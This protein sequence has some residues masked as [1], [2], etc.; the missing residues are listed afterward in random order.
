MS[1]SARSVPTVPALVYSTYAGGSEDDEPVGIGIDAS[2]NAYVAGNTRSTDYPVSNGAY[3]TSFGSIFITALDPTGWLIYSTYF[4]SGAILGFGPMASANGIAVDAAGDA[5]VIGADGDQSVPTTANVYQTTCPQP[6]FPNPQSPDCG[7]VTKLN[8]LGTALVYSTYLGFGTA[9]SAI[10]IDSNGEAFIGG[11]LSQAEHSGGF[12]FP[13]NLSMVNCL[14]ATNCVYEVKLD[15]NGA[16]LLFATTSSYS[17][18]N[19]I[20]AGVSQSIVVDSLGIAHLLAL[21]ANG[22]RQYYLFSFDPSGGLNPVVLPLN[23]ASQL[24]PRAIAL[25]SNNNVFISGTAPNAQLATTPD[26][27]QPTFAGGLYDGFLTELDPTG[28]FVLYTTYLGGSGNDYAQGLAVD[29][30]GNAYVTGTTNSTDFPVTEGAFQPNLGGPS[31]NALVARIVPSLKLS[32]TPT[33]TIT[34]TPTTTSTATPVVVTPTVTT[35]PTPTTPRT[36]LPTRTVEPTATTPTATGSP[37]PTPTATA[38][39]T[40]TIT[41]TSTPTPTRTATIEPSPGGTPF[42]NGTPTPTTTVTT[43]MTATITPTPTA[44]ATPVG[45][46]TYSPKSEELKFP[47]R[48]VNT[49]SGVKF[50]TVSNPKKN[51]AAI[52]ISSIQLGSLTAPVGCWG[53]GAGQGPPACG[54][55]IDAPK[56]TCQAGGSIA[57][58]KSCRVAIWFSPSAKGEW[59]ASLLIT[60]NMSNPGAIGLTG[61]GR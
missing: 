51:K 29:A 23:G 6:G 25:D 22:G 53:E 18:N 10:A 2:G 38:T 20:L 52:T 7:F 16:N 50:V 35:T 54:F 48:K 5:F 46:V 17:T 19:T 55:G 44:T 9:A 1:S 58:D 12:L 24:S 59:T 11:T 36:P 26:A 37:R 33:K 47:T 42:V 15:T 14:A 8:P 28:Y 34:P 13:N 32:P 21:D 40:A 57:A 61:A 39:E 43:T 56:T 4:D 30:F 60:G 27:F 3:Q 31:G 41:P 45:I 49:V